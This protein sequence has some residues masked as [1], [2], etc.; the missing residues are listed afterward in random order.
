MFEAMIKKEVEEVTEDQEDQETLRYIEEMCRSDPS[1]IGTEGLLYLGEYHALNPEDQGKQNAS[2]LRNRRITAGPHRKGG[3]NHQR[4]RVA[5]VPRRA[6]SSRRSRIKA[7]RR[8]KRDVKSVITLS[9]SHCDFEGP[10]N[11]HDR[12]SPRSNYY[13]QPTPSSIPT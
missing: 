3:T 11:G 13:G 4:R 9:L 2:E 6:V 7:R 10:R 1:K 5:T 8:K 12:H